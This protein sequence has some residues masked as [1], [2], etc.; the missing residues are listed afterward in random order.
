MKLDESLSLRFL[1][2]RSAIINA[3]AVVEIEIYT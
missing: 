3:N 2:D 1:Y